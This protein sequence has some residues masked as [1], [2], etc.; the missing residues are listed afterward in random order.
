MKAFI[1]ILF[2]IAM[3]FPCFSEK[4]SDLHIN[5]KDSVTFNI[6]SKTCTA[7]GSVSIQKDTTSL[8]SDSAF[9]QFQKKDHRHRI[10]FLHAKGNVH[11]DIPEGIVTGGKAFYYADQKRISIKDCVRFDGTD[12]TLWSD[13][14]NVLFF[15]APH[16]NPSQPWVLRSISSPKSIYFQNKEVKVKGKSGSYNHLQKKATVK[17]ATHIWHKESYISAEG[18][19]VDLEKK[20]YF[21]KG[22]NHKAR[23]LILIEKNNPENRKKHGSCGKKS[24]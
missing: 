7:K 10:S 1:S 2:C 11:I 9:V 4:K 15:G 24:L 23:S 20:C 19:I 5:A 14:L 16:E 3:T 21:V 17:G 22:R 6:Q 18:A 12:T 13:C 8:R